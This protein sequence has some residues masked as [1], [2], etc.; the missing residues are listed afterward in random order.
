MWVERC[1]SEPSGE[2]GRDVVYQAQ[3]RGQTRWGAQ[4]EEQVGA[5]GRQGRHGWIAGIGESPRQLRA[6]AGLPPAVVHP[7]RMAEAG[8]PR[9]GAGL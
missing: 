8:A 2:P 4:V 9:W 6:R 7:S 1:A 3:V 5:L